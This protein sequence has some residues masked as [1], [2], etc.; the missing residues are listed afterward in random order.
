MLAT[1]ELLLALSTVFNVLFYGK[2]VVV[3]GDSPTVGSTYFLYRNR[4][5][6]LE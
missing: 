5:L 3:D 6:S 1:T 4:A 2:V